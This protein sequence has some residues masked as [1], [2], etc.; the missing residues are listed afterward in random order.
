MIRFKA[1]LW[2]YPGDAAWHFVTLPPEAAENIRDDGPI[3]RGFG[4]VKVEAA[5]GATKWNTSVFPDSASGSYVLPVK[6]D[7]R[8]AEAIEPGDPVDV[9]LRVL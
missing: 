9:E 6:K 1:E 3:R 8:H 4:S 7:V 2:M 5:I